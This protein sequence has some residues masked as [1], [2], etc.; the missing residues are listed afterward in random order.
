[1]ADKTEKLQGPRLKCPHAY[2]R[3]EDADEFCSMAHQG[4]RVIV[5]G[6]RDFGD[7]RLMSAV[8]DRLELTPS[9]EIVSGHARG[10]DSLGER[11]A[12]EHGIPLKLF[13]AEWDKYGKRAGYLRNKAM[14]EY[15]SAGEGMLVAFPVGESRGTRMM[16]RLAEEAGL[17]VVVKE[18][19]KHA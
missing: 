18:G 14:A 9:D 11:Y 3:S 1:M 17:E 2:L 13:P 10:A 12:A 5:A 6:S 16:I 15:A 7:Y 19:E 4:R 8:L